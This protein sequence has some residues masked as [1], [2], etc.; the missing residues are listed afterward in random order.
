MLLTGILIE[1]VILIAVIV[2]M[3]KTWNKF[4]R[5]FNWNP[6]R[7]STNEKSNQENK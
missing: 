2:F 4:K 7:R 3:Y 5:I 1:L 6:F